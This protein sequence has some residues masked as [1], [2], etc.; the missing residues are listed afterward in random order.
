MSLTLIASHLLCAWLGACAGACG[1]VFF[2]AMGGA[3]KRYDAE[4][5]ELAKPYGSRQERRWP[6]L[7]D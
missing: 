4:M 6:R 1:A 7:V 5:E 3:A 2:L